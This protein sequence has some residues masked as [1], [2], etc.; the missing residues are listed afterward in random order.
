[1][2][3]AII[4]DPIHLVFSIIFT[5]RY[6]YAHFCGF[7]VTGISSSVFST[8]FS[9]ELVVDHNFSCKINGEVL[10]PTGLQFKA[11][12]DESSFGSLHFVLGQ[13]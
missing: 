1:M 4:R 13:G 3:E 8:V 2:R 12:W 7:S 6:F 11:V 10:W 9:M 5:F